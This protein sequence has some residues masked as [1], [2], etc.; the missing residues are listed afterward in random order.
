M[1]FDDISPPTIPTDHPHPNLHVH[2]QFFNHNLLQQQQLL[3]LL[4]AGNHL[5]DNQALQLPANL[6]TWP[7]AVIFDFVY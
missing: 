4:V 3:G 1:G 7:R 2:L 5:C 6:D